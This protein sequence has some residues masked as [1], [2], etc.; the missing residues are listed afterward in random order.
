MEHKQIERR[1]ASV[2][3]IALEPAG[4]APEPV[5]TGWRVGTN[6]IVTNRHVACLLIG[7]EIPP[8]VVPPDSWSKNLALPCVIDFAMVNQPPEP[9]R[10]RLSKVAWCAGRSGPDLAFLELKAS[11]PGAVPDPL[12]IN[13]EAAALGQ[14]GSGATP[15][16][17]QGRKIYVV[18]HPYSDGDSSAVAEVFGRADGRKRF[19]PG[20]VTRIRPTG[21][22]DHDCSTLGG[23]SGSCVLSAETHDVLGIHFAGVSVDEE[24]VGA[25]NVALSLAGM[26]SARAKEILT[27]GQV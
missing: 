18:G 24:E 19:S 2:G 7:L 1:S 15:P 26:S 4:S 22:F 6:L 9:R 16:D 20:C 11:R 10:F 14:G 27:R 21:I 25:S 23:N 3:R 8:E 12:P 5:G 13:W 17:F